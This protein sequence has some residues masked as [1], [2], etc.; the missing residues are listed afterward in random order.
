LRNAR[1][2]LSVLKILLVKNVLL[3]ISFLFLILLVSCK[4]DSKEESIDSKNLEENTLIKNDNKIE[5]ISIVFYEGK[6]GIKFQPKSNFVFKLK[7]GSSYLKYNNFSK[8]DLSKGIE[9]SILIRENEKYKIDSFFKHENTL[10]KNDYGDVI[11]EKPIFKIFFMNKEQ[12]VFKFININGQPQ[13]RSILG[14][15]ASCDFLLE[16]VKKKLSTIN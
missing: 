1:K 11:G 3:L 12:K 7:K 13:D 5:E 4:S 10:L 15:K 16:K 8:K 9:D 6:R 14:L 2:D